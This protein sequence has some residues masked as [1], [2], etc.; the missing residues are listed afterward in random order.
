[1]SSSCLNCTTLNTE[2]YCPNCGQKST[3]HRYSIQ[4]FIEHDFIHGV[5]HVDK[6]IFFTLREL[7]TR[8][9]HSIREYI[10]GKRAT[11]FSFITFLLLILTINA[12]MASYSD[13]KMSD[14]IPSSSKAVM[15][16]FEKFTTQYP[17]LM[18]AITIPI[19]SVFS[20]LW[21]KKAR[22]NYSEHLVANSYKAVAELIVSLVFAV[23]MIIYSNVKV[24]MFIYFGVVTPLIYIYDIWYYYQMF[25]VYYKTKRELF[26]R[27]FM[28]V[29]SYTFLIVLVGV[30]FGIM[31]GLKR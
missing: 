2:K 12:L 15:N 24:L 7:F 10:Q 17:K 19:N 14:L 26:L 4:H 18:L 29:F 8:P 5:F 9:G 11:H 6:G 27:S 13:V 16:S 21:F 28:V 20:Y 22:F 1:M 23:L 3:T 25:S 31:E 30:F